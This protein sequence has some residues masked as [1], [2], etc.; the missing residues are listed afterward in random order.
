MRFTL[1]YSA[2]LLI[3]ALL[4][5]CSAHNAPT[6]PPPNGGDLERAVKNATKSG[7]HMGWSHGKDT[8]SKFLSGKNAT[9]LYK[10][11][12]RFNKTAEYM[13]NLFE[14]DDTL[15]IDEETLDN[16]EGPMVFFVEPIPDLSRSTGLR[17]EK[18]KPLHSE[19]NRRY[20]YGTDV[21]KLHSKPGASKILYLDFNGHDLTG[22]AWS[23]SS[24]M[25][26]P[27]CDWDKNPSS[28]SETEK[29]YIEKIW[30]R[31]A[32]DYAPFDVDVTTELASESLITR[33]SKSDTFYGNR[34]L[35][36]PGIAAICN[37]NCGGISY[38]GIYSRT[39]EPPAA[40]VYSCVEQCRACTA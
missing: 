22:T 24:S 12:K 39:G 36:S 34:V 4:V 37:N 35:I 18:N 16:A 3:A 38:V 31:V 15:F 5:F 2:F 20:L 17:E 23:P 11:A 28:F 8:V 25:L 40:C 13:Q 32:E 29:G 7:R 33:S 10:L 21:F 27:P 30:S 1:G 19:S 9:R 26:A 6:A 14:S